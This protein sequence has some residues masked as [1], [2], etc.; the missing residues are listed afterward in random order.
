MSWLKSWVCAILAHRL[1][2]MAVVVLPDHEGKHHPIDSIVIIP[3]PLVSESVAI[4]DRIKGWNRLYGKDVPGW[5]PKAVELVGKGSV[6]GVVVWGSRVCSD[7]G[8][9]ESHDG[10]NDRPVHLSIALPANLPCDDQEDQE[11][12]GKS[13]L[14]LL[15]S[16]YYKASKSPRT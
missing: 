10:V 8:V 11:E 14:L 5:V 9:N 2:S 1:P 4:Q 12:K 3:H 13:T 6:E 15:H 16:N 7:V